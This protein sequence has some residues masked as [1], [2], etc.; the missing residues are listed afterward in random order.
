MLSLSQPLLDGGRFLEGPAALVSPGTI[1][2][3]NLPI[4]CIDHHRE[5]DALNDTAE[6]AFALA[7]G[8]ADAILAGDLRQQPSMF[9]GNNAGIARAG[10]WPRGRQ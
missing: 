5:R 7:Q 6:S 8:L 9:V 1:E 10:I 2:H 3:D 4:L